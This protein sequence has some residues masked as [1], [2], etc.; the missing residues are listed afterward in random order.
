M[1]MTLAGNLKAV[2]KHISIISLMGSV[3]EDI[4]H[5]YSHVSVKCNGRIR[6]G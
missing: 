5:G 4:I 2:Q 6:K 1:S 3:K